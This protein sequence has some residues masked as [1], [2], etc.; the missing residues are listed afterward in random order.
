MPTR[1][2]KSPVTD[3]VDDAAVADDA[4]VLDDAAV[5]DDLEGP[6]RLARLVPLAHAAL[7]PPT[8]RAARAIRAAPERPGV[9]PDGGLFPG[10]R[11]PVF[12]IGATA[13]EVSLS[14]PRLEAMLRA[15][16]A[17]TESPSVVW[18]RGDSELAVHCDRARVALGTGTV[19]VGVRVE[20]DQSG[21]AEITVPLAVGSPDLAA[22]MVMATPSR[23]DGPALLVEQWG[24]VVVAAVY[25]A[26]LDV[27]SAVAATAGVDRDGKPLLPGAVSTDGNV[28]T[29]VPQAR[30]AIDRRQLL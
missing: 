14:R 25:R 20:C 21:P 6:E 10:G 7:S 28:L 18:V 17:L 1:R 13:K 15:A 4:P 26:V 8:E 30:H 24:E 27:V 5:L 16:L 11:I 23:P 22:G 12:N 29:V 9:R 3:L 19:V 2:R